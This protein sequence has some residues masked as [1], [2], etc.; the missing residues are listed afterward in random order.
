MSTISYQGG[1]Y[2][3]AEREFYG[4][5]TV[6][7]SQVNPSDSSVYRSVVSTYK[8]DNFYGRGL[9]ESQVTQDGAG[10]RFTETINSYD[11][12]TVQAGRGGELEDFTATRF[13][14][15]T[16]TDQRF[17]EGQASPGKS[18][19]QT[20]GY[21]SLG[22]VT[23]FVDAGD[24]G[25]QDDLTAAITYSSCSATNVVG[26]ATGITVTSN[27]AEVRR[28]EA[29]IDCAT[30]DMTQMRQYL[31]DGTAAQTDLDY[32][33]N[34]NLQRVTGPTNAT[35]QRYQVAY[36]YDPD[37]DTFITGITD[38]FG[39]SS[40]AEYNLKYGQVAA[41]ADINN[42][43]TSYTYDLFGRVDT[44]RGPYEQS[45]Q[46]PPTIRF[47]YHPEGNTPW[48]LTKHYDPYRNQAGT[49]TIDTVLFTDGF[50]RVL[51]T[52]KD[53]TVFTGYDTPS[54][55]VM[56]VAGRVNFDFVGRIARQYYPIT[57]TLSINDAGKGTFNETYDTITPTLMLYDVLDRNTQTTIPDGTSTSTTYG[58]GTDRAGANQFQTTVQDANTN[59]TNTFKDVRGL[60][61]SVE[62]FH[63]S[64][65]VWTSY[66]Y[67]PMK[68]LLQVTDANNNVTHVTYDNL[69]RTT[70]QNNPDTGRTDMTYDLAGNLTTKVTADL[71][72]EGRQIS[73][74]YD[75][76][77]LTAITYPDNPAN[78][79]TY[80]YG[81][82]GASDNRAGRIT[83]V[84]DGSGSED[85]FYGKL[86]E[87][88]REVK[89]CQHH[90][91]TLSRYLHHQLRVRHVGAHAEHD[92]PRR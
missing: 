90:Q 66:A 20:F 61:T 69:G 84:T 53:G 4:F 21:D 3:R 40:S 58:F 8:N 30:G 73:Y 49:D 29:T 11:M 32:F 54:Q 46:S 81:G 42:S 82:V 76:N 45:P 26:K 36:T 51:Q 41:S 86:G 77:R 14:R 13:P 71:R 7:V 2:D 85:S 34:G 89:S 91:R 55:D 72:S 24:D 23:Q 79:V 6:T 16:R 18:T 65:P 12:A 57:E 22:N 74:T 43:V 48:A 33:P 19:Y 70:S 87:L 15:L 44:I 80:S 28:R 5:R 35:N 1:K 10:H 92:L 67:D 56:E 17:Y 78:N 31:A 68:E 9:L 25:A 39:Y 38:S 47:S 83:T 52:K 63:N 50:K 59:R 27:G 75:R 37:V 64:Q 62:E 88:T 60:V